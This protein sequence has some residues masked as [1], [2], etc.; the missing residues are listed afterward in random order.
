MIHIITKIDSKETRLYLNDTGLVVYEVMDSDQILFNKKVEISKEDF[1]NLYTEII[2]YLDI[3]TTSRWNQSTNF[4]RIETEDTYYGSPDDFK[5]DLGQSIIQKIHDT[6]PIENLEVITELERKELKLSFD[7]VSLQE[8]VFG[9]EAFHDELD[10]YYDRKTGKVIISDDEEI[11]MLDDRF[12]SLPDATDIHE[13]QL[14]E[15]FVSE[16]ENDKN[17]RLLL[18][19]IDGKGAFSRFKRMIFELGYRDVWFRYRNQ[20]Y[21]KLARDWI[22]AHKLKIR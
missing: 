6:I 2:L 5:D 21:E 19:A 1:Y 9:I 3:Y 17:K 13:Y 8:V 11:L 10:H 14:M 16:I 20:A 12:L 18:M 22:K 4:W 15:S 7:T